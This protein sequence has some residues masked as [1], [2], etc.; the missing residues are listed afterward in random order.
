M[1]RLLDLFCVPE[2]NASEP[3]REPLL[4]Q[5]DEDDEILIPVKK[6]RSL[7]LSPNP[8]GRGTSVVPEWYSNMLN[9]I[10]LGGEPIFDLNSLDNFIEL[11]QFVTLV[12]DKYVSNASIVNLRMDYLTGDN[13]KAIILLSSCSWISSIHMRH[14]GFEWIDESFR[15]WVMCEGFKFLG[16]LTGFDF[17]FDNMG[18]NDS[19]PL[20]KE[21]LEIFYNLKRLTILPHQHVLTRGELNQVK[22]FCGDSFGDPFELLNLE[23]IQFG[24]Q[25]DN[26]PLRPY[27]VSIMP[28]FVTFFQMSRLR[29]IMLVN[30]SMKLEDLKEFLS[31]APGAN[32]LCF[33]HCN[34]DFWKVMNVLVEEKEL[35]TRP[36]KE[37]DF[38]FELGK[39]SRLE[40]EKFDFTIFNS[41]ENF[42]LKGNTIQLLDVILPQ[43]NSGLKSLSF[44]YNMSNEVSLYTWTNLLGSFKQLEKLGINFIS[45]KGKVNPE[46]IG[47]A[48]RN[49]IIGDALEELALFGEFTDYG[50]TKCLSLIGQTTFIPIFYTTKKYQ[51]LDSFKN[52]RVIG[53]YILAKKL[54]GVI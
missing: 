2:G 39:V 4:L 25:V 24:S 1:T 36:W 54:P 40:N 32:S 38:E 50:I 46:T 30:F 41:I 29:K 10:K 35:S 37:F 47:L 19:L 51:S 26:G 34:L 45:N 44:D 11:S 12:R 16:L 13:K 31:A 15:A 33:K 9:Q 21:L 23:S 6:I 22:K 3:E 43:L 49:M 48:I 42:Y 28:F 53:N 5:D 18:L 14:V 17:D 7:E 27:T 20:L 8:N 52:N